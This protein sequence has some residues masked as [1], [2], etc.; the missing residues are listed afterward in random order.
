MLN[1]KRVKLNNSKIPDFNAADDFF[2]IIVLAHIISAAMQVLN[3]SDIDSDL[4]SNDVLSNDEWVKEQE[5]RRD[6]L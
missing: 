4:G 2:K 5:E 6:G 3:M 1:H